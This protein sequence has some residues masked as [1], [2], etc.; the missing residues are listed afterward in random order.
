MKNTAQKLISYAKK[1][2]HGFTVR[3]KKEKLVE[4]KP[5]KK[6]RYAVSVT[7]FKTK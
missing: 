3:I 5:S 7:N 6:N 2:P 4:V 1:H